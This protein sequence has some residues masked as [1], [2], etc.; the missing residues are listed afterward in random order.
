MNG[1]LD[2][3][4]VEIPDSIW[5]IDFEKCPLGNTV[6]DLMP[7][8]RDRCTYKDLFVGMVYCRHPGKW[9]KRFNYPFIL[10]DYKDTLLKRSALVGKKYFQ[11]EKKLI[12]MGYFNTIIKEDL[13]VL[14]INNF[15]FFSLHCI[16]LIFLDM[17]LLVLLLK[18]QRKT[19]Q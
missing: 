15:V 3:A 2:K 10:N 16:I 19:V 17:N 9:E 5:A 13:P 18:K 4:A 14:V 6:F 1:T 11:Q 12:E 8:K 7:V